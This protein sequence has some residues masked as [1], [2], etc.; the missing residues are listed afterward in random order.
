MAQRVVV[1]GDVQGVG[2]RWWCSREASRLGLRGWVRNRQDGGVE[3]LVEGDDDAVATMVDELRHGPRHAVVREFEVSEA[4]PSGM[5]H[6]VVE[7]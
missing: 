7:S 5:P 1:H 2:F 4:R 3:A 6:F